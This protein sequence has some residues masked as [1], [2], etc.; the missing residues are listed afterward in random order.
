MNLD[1]RLVDETVVVEPAAE[2]RQY[3][4]RVDEF[5]V[6]KIQTAAE[7]AQDYEYSYYSGC[8][9]PDVIMLLSLDGTAPVLV[10]VVVTAHSADEDDYLYT[11]YELRDAK[12][13][14]H[15]RFTVKIDGRA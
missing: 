2:L 10:T 6:W 1:D 9:R 14:A 11:T 5:E 15:D 4:T 3:L 12:G 7:I 8:G 13:S